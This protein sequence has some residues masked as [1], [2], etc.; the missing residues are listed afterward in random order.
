MTK[1]G[2]GI[3]FKRCA[4]RFLLTTLEQVARS[5]PKTAYYITIMGSG[6]VTVCS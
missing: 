2:Y 6:N 4:V 5:V 3:D 1:L